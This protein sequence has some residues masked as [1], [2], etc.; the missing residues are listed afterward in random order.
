MTPFQM[1]VLSWLGG[2]VAGA[3]VAKQHRV[4]GFALGALVVGAVAD[5]L[6]ERRHPSYLSH[7]SF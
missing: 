3:V 5:V 1:S 2:G 6:I 7:R 4:A